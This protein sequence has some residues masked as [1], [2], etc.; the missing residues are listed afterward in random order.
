M[1]KMKHSTRYN[2]Y[3]WDLGPTVD[4]GPAGGPG[5][6]GDPDLAVDPGS[7]G[8]W[9]RLWAWAQQGPRVGAVE[10]VV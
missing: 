6:G 10:V 9:T 5:P 7:A 8:T 1:H 4:S 3:I 2:K